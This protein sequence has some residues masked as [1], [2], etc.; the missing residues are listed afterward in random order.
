M[1]GGNIDGKG[2][3]L[4]IDEVEPHSDR[5]VAEAGH[6]VRRQDSSSITFEWRLLWGT[7]CTHDMV[8][9][10][11]LFLDFKGREWRIWTAGGSAFKGSDGRDIRIEPVLM[12]D[13]PMMR[14]SIR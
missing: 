11:H 2:Y 14:R 9:E 1:E 4:M 6:V 10:W 5:Y 3:S 7:G 12:H 8:V 13:A